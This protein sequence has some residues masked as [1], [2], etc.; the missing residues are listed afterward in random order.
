MQTSINFKQIPKIF[1]VPPQSVGNLE[2]RNPQ[3]LCLNCSHV[4]YSWRFMLW[5]TFAAYGQCY[6]ILL[7]YEN[8]AIERGRKMLQMP[9]VKK[10]WEVGDTAKSHVLSTDDIALW[11]L[12]SDSSYVFTDITYGLPR[13][14]GWSLVILTLQTFLLVTAW[15][16]GTVGWALDFQVHLLAGMLIHIDSGQAFYMLVCAVTIHY[17]LVVV[18]GWQCS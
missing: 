12:K 18:K 8:E 4:K 17:S 11:D 14:V 16:G 9:P 5:K 15:S 1:V 7:Q 13:R 3:S 10:S 6:T 2:G